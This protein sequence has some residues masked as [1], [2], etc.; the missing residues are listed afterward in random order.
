M[1]TQGWLSIRS[2]AR[3]CALTSCRPRPAPPCKSLDTS[4]VA[5]NLAASES[6]NRTL[7]LMLQP[8]PT[9]PIGPQLSDLSF[10]AVM[11]LQSAAP[12]AGWAVLIQQTGTIT[13]NLVITFPPGK[14]GT[15][16]GQALLAAISTCQ[17]QLGTKRITLD[18]GAARAPPRPPPPSPPV[19]AAKAWGDPHFIGFDG[20][21]GCSGSVLGS[22]PP[23]KHHA[24]IHAGSHGLQSLRRRM[25]QDAVDAK[26]EP[27]PGD[28]AGMVSIPCPGSAG[29]QFDFHGAPGTWKDLLV[30]P[31]LGL[32]LTCQVSCTSGLPCQQG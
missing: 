26:E 21:Q 13:A 20:E 19:Q 29:V 6:R 18:P 9:K 17:L 32:R 22:H 24:G 10:K 5:A 16:S 7:T 12:G 14:A 2:D 8:S 3:T 4:A 1:A 23:G 25:K 11:L 28:R 15:K 31:R 30:S 27:G